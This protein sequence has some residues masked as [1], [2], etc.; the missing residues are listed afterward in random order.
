M[1]ASEVM[2]KRRT[3]LG[4]AVRI[5]IFCGL[6]G[7]VGAGV[8]AIGVYVVYA[9]TVPQFDS[10]DDYQPKIGSRIYS[11]DNQP[12]MLSFA[13]SAVIGEKSKNGMV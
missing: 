6:V 5:A 9:P 1:L 10:L 4:W 3:K 7:I 11:A 13:I 12:F 2:S 8:V